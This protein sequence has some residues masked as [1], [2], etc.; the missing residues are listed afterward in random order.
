MATQCSDSDSDPGP[1]APS[2][3]NEEDIDTH[4]GNF[5]ADKSV[6]ARQLIEGSKFSLL[7]RMRLKSSQKK[8]A[9]K[10]TTFKLQT[11]RYTCTM[12]Y[13]KLMSLY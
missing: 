6:E 1:V 11:L 3:E 2:C 4:Q 9:R 8:V 7:V 5:G 10:N 13:K 12:N